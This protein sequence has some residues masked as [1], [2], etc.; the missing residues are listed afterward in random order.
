MIPG[1]K[2]SPRRRE[3]LPTL[4]FWPGEFH[5]QRGALKRVGHDR[6]TFASWHCS[7]VPSN[8]HWRRDSCLGRMSAAS[9]RLTAELRLRPGPG[10]HA[11]PVLT[12]PSMLSRKWTW[13]TEQPLS[14]GLEGEALSPGSHPPALKAG[15]AWGHGGTNHLGDLPLG[16]IPPHPCQ[17]QAKPCAP[18]G[19]CLCRREIESVK[20]APA[21]AVRDIG[22]AW[23]LDR[24]SPSK[25]GSGLQGLT[26]RPAPQQSSH[27][28]FISKPEP[29][30]QDS[31]SVEEDSNGPPSASQALPGGQGPLGGSLQVG[32]EP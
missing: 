25:P 26:Q 6:A 14:P 12:R 30:P 19:P 16:S 15:R 11:C 4:V 18:R 13:R 1:L 5:G 7:E 17:T 31:K 28:S 29:D 24:G 3:W 8:G 23:S 2:R 32:E 22:R 27:F 20:P 10:C 9:T 21:L